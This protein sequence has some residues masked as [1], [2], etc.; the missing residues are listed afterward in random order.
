MRFDISFISSG[1]TYARRQHC[2]AMITLLKEKHDVDHRFVVVNEPGDITPQFMASSVKIE[3]LNDPRLH[4]YNKYSRPLHVRHISN[5]MKHMAALDGVAKSVSADGTVFVVLE[6]DVLATSDW[7]S[8]LEGAANE[9][10]IKGYEFF[11]LGIPGKTGSAEKL[12]SKKQV[13]PCCDS[14]MLSKSAASKIA[15]AF[16]PI[17]FATNVH[18]TYIL[19]SLN[20]RAYY[21]GSVVFLDGSKYGGFISVINPNNMLILNSDYVNARRK[22]IEEGESDAGKI[23]E[24]VASIETSPFSKHPDFVHLLAV[25]DWRIFGAHQANNRFKLAMQTYTS[26]MAVLNSESRFLRDYISLHRDLQ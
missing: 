18:L 25:A 14:Y 20:M 26:N 13:L 10:A 9:M 22:L 19:N 5:S 3:Q 4:V 17:R 12:D 6:D 1:I 24:I 23:K 8:K 15:S 21:G 7:I 16:L 11:A 2:E